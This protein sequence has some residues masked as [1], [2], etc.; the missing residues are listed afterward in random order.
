[1]SVEELARLQARA[2]EL[3]DRRAL[4]MLE[5]QENDAASQAMAL[6]SAL[7]DA[8]PPRGFEQLAGRAMLLA[9]QATAL[10]QAIADADA[11]VSQAEAAAE[12]A[13]Q[14]A[15]RKAVRAHLQERLQLAGDI[16]AALRALLPKLAAFSDLG[17]RIERRA[18]V[19][20]GHPRILPALAPEAAGGRLAE[21]MAGIGFGAWLPLTRPETRPALAALKEG[22]E[23]LQRPYLARF[24]EEAVR[25]ALP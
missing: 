14:A 17:S 8:T 22:E 25:E 18:S 7:E 10:D 13:R 6:K 2:S 3:S 12:M 21:F 9:A 16:E 1:M 20:E 15:E 23:A 11:A 19:L 24:A 4:I 5:Q